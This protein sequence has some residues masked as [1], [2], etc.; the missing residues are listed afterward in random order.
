VEVIATYAPLV[1]WLIPVAAALRGGSLGA[2]AITDTS[3]E[4]GNLLF[5]LPREVRVMALGLFLQNLAFGSLILVF[6]ELTVGP[7]GLSAGGFALMVA[8]GGAPAVL[9]L[10]PMGKLADRIGRRNAV[11]YPMMV[12]A[13]LIATAP[14]LSYLRVDPVVR[15]MIIVPGLLVAGVAYALM[16]PAWHALAL[17]R[18][19]EAQ[20]GRCLALLMSIEMVAMAG[21]HVIG[22]SL[23][24]KVSFMA[25]FLFAGFTFAA[26]AAVYMAG[27]ILPPDVPEEPQPVDLGPVSSL[28]DAS[29]GVRLV[30]AD[31]AP[32]APPSHPSPSSGPRPLPRTGE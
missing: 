3:T 6:R 4:G 17:G 11:I 15:F 30:P 28:A 14:L 10:G 23:Y 26:L 16:L 2:P 12:V 19:P 1:L 8:L 20:R 22:P 24:E 29:C 18:I 13:P 32:P 7:L 27:Y 5:G 25:P 21:G 9:L 31:P